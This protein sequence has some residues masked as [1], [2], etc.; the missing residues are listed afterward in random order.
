[1]CSNLHR[2]ADRRPRLCVKSA[3]DAPRKFVPIILSSSNLRTA[4]ASVHLS[5]ATAPAD[6][7]TTVHTDTPSAHT[8]CND[9]PH[10][11]APLINCDLSTS[12]S[13]IGPASRKYNGRRSLRRDDARRPTRWRFIRH[14]PE[15]ISFSFSVSVRFRYGS[16]KET[17]V[18]VLLPPFPY[19]FIPFSIFT[20]SCFLSL[21]AFEQSVEPARRNLRS[22]RI[23]TRIE[24]GRSTISSILVMIYARIEWTKPRVPTSINGKFTSKFISF[25]SS[26]TIYHIEFCSST[27]RRWNNVTSMRLIF[28][29]T[30]VY[31]QP[32]HTYLYAISS[33]L[34]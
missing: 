30:G 15:P 13:P 33:S 12:K 2:R 23:S 34:L 14:P 5:P 8:N 19:L 16:P 29:I 28:E 7:H 27:L 1:M 11:Y 3:D 25:L 18:S 4:T 24:T 22:P 32:L 9:M 10:H 26:T 21:L 6:T 31:F 17:I 20:P